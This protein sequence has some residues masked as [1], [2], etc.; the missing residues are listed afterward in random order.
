[1]TIQLVTETRYTNSRVVMPI[2]PPTT[3]LT[4]RLALETPPSN[5]EQKPWTFSKELARLNGISM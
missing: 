3:L 2:A 1:M 4:E 5:G